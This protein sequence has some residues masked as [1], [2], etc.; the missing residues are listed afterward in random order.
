M[1]K[2]LIIL[3]L[4][5]IALT[6]PLYTGVYILHIFSSILIF[7]ALSLSWDMMLRTGQLSFGTAGFFGL[8]AYASVLIVVNMGFN[9]I[10]SLLIGAIF[11]GFIAFILGFIV[12]RLR[13]IYF[14]ITTLALTHVFSVIIRNFS[15]FTGGASG[16]ILASAIFEGDPV[17]IYY[18]VLIVA[19]LAIIISEVFKRSRIHY[20][21]NAIRNDET[22]AKS[23]GI[24]VF[25]YLLFVFVSTSALQGLVGAVYAHQYAF[26]NPEST[27][28]LNFLLLPIAMALVG[29][30]YSTNG[31]IIGALLLGLIS[32]YLKLIMPYGHLIVYGLIIVFVVLFLPRGIYSTIHNKLLKSN[33][34][35]GDKNANTASK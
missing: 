26:V 14:A 18:L 21:I 2:N 19:G 20:A 23:S 12:L 30:I 13:E 28:S 4:I 29:G 15:D 17:K 33:I 16:K 31:P 6:L 35:G 11:S 7:L 1:R 25:K 10:L 3:L 8:G 5:V 9:P 32:E 34:I 24:D 22:T 27:F